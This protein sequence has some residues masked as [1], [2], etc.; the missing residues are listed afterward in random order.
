VA[1]GA[2]DR[3]LVDPRR[4][5]LGVAARIGLPATHL[6]A[7][8]GWASRDHRALVEVVH[9]GARRRLG[10]VAAAY[11]ATLGHRVCV[12]VP[13]AGDAVAWRTD[14]TAHAPEVRVADPDAPAAQLDAADVAL[15][16]DPAATVG[17]D[18]VVVADVSA[19]P[20]GPLASPTGGAAPL[21]LGLGG[22]GDATRV[23]A[24]G[25]AVLGPV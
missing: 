2:P 11:G 18:L 21:V 13:R 12:L 15:T 19:H 22:Q 25:L 14:L 4:L 20:P 3:V 24:P 6:A 7:V 1:G 10:V 16:S 17:A 23:G 8:Q 5:L 9:P